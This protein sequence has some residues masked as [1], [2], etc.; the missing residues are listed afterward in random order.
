MS[1]LERTTMHPRC[2]L[3]KNEGSMVQTYRNINVHVVQTD[4]CYINVYGYQK[5]QN[6]KCAQYKQ[7]IVYKT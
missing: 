5:K 2:R 3:L 6:Y 1:T 4:I 7:K